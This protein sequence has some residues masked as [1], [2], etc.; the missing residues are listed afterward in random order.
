MSGKIKENGS[1]TNQNIKEKIEISWRKIFAWVALLL[2]TVV[3]EAAIGAA[4]VSCSLD[5]E[6][7]DKESIIISLIAFGVS[8][9][10]VITE[11]ISKIFFL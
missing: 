3:P 6:K 11:F 4:I 10:M 9:F 8:C 7:E 5:T 2:S 1:T